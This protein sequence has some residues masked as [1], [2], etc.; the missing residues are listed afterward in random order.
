MDPKKFTQ[1]VYK[2]NQFLLINLEFYIQISN[3]HTP[4]KCSSPIYILEKIQPFS[5]V[6]IL[7]QCFFEYY[8][9]FATQLKAVCHPVP[10]S[11]MSRG[12]LITCFFLRKLGHIALCMEITWTTKIVCAPD[13]SLGNEQDIFFKKNFH[14]KI[15]RY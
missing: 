6:G 10:N 15:L 4:L 1:D 14:R 2:S 13:K 11:H 12:S 9:Y 7:I 8:R 5:L 3:I